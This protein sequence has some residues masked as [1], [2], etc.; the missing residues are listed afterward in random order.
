MGTKLSLPSKQYV[1]FSIFETLSN[2]ILLEL[3]DYL[4]S[5]EI[6]A[7]F[8]HLNNRLDNLIDSYPQHV[9]FQFNMIVPRYIRSLKIT[10]TNQVPLYFSLHSSQ[11]SNIRGLTLSNLYVQQLHDMLNI[12]EF[13][14][15]EYIYLGVCRESITQ[16]DL[17]KSV[18][19]KILTLGKYCLRRCHLRGH[20]LVNI[21]DLPLSLPSLEY[22]HLDGCE[23]FVVLSLFISRMPNLKFLRVSLLTSTRYPLQTV[24]CR[25]TH[26]V[27]RFHSD[28]S[29]ADLKIFFDTCCSYV[30][31]LVIESC[32][33]KF[34]LPKL[35]VNKQKW[36]EILPNRIT[37]FHLK[38]IISV[39]DYL[40]FNI[41]K[42]SQFYDTISLMHN[43][44]QNRL[45]QTIIEEPFSSV[46]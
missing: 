24:S 8:G 23:N 22:I 9:N 16:N 18:Q 40:V 15:L 19:T 6:Y 27:L 1:G 10:S 43:E 45:C 33:E 2:D 4:F 14:Q 41:I 37:W 46:W 20:L 34:Y 38:A 11:L 36:I 25:I 5:N 17:I 7:S 31:K 21:N 35:L 30:E 26:L 13:Q 44:Y 12:I 3:F 28:C 39:H 29:I 32:T 42:R